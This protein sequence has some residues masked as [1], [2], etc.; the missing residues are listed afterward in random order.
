MSS[1]RK[2]GHAR[3]CGATPKRR[4]RRLTQSPRRE[5]RLDTRARTVSTPCITPQH[6]RSHQEV[7]RRPAAKADND[8]LRAR[9]STALSQRQEPQRGAANTP[10]HH[11]SSCASMSM[12]PLNTPDVRAVRLAAAAS[13]SHQPA[14]PAVDDEEGR[15]KGPKS[16]RTAALVTYNYTECAAH[17]R[18]RDAL[19]KCPEGIPSGT[20]RTRFDLDG[21]G[22][23]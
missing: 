11:C 2:A 4:T 7:A 21:G 3:A 16:H 5:Q 9:S 14:Q 17:R 6:R 10:H 22:E 1:T 20:C 13:L 19:C 23:T 15:P 18:N 12:P 8:N